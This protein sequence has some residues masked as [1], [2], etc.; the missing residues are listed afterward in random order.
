MALAR[1]YVGNI[2]FEIGE[3]DIRAIFERCGPIRSVQLTKVSPSFLVHNIHY[4]LCMPD[5]FTPF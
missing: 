2:Y 3:D 5:T 1:V 4:T